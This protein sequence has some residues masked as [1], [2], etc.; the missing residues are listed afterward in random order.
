MQTAIRFDPLRLPPETA[1][2]RDQIRTF[3]AGEA[4]RG[5]FDPAIGLRNPGYD[6]DFSQRV[7]ARGWIGMT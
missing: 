2:L 4:A 3:L 6:R 7:G 5:T 1:K